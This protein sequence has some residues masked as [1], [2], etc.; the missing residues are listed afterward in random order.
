MQVKSVWDADRAKSRRV[1]LAGLFGCSWA[2]LVM[3]VVVIC[4]IAM[5]TYLVL[6]LTS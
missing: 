6:I 3:A 5:I 1:D 2:L 4:V